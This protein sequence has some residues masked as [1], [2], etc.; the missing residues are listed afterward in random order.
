MNHVEPLSAKHD[1]GTFNNTVKPYA[2]DYH[3]ET[4]L[5]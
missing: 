1:Y 2:A 5:V 3:V 4:M